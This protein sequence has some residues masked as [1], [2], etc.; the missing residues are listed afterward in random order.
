MAD[1]RIE[2][3]VDDELTVPGHTALTSHNHT[4]GA[5]ALTCDNCGT[6]LGRFPAGRWREH[7]IRRAWR[8]HLDGGR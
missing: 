2:A 5:Q 6:A 7:Q 1:H 4:T 3:F 8:A